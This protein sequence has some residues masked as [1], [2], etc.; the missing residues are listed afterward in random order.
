[1]KMTIELSDKDL[2]G[3]DKETLVGALDKMKNMLEAFK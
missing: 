2:D 3:L 1:M